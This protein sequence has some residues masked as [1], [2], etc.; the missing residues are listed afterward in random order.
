MDTP[1]RV[2]S[3]DL[4]LIDRSIRGNFIFNKEKNIE[5]V[6]NVLNY[7]D[8]NMFEISLSAKKKDSETLFRLETRIALEQ[9][10]EHGHQYPHLQINNFASDEDLM[11]KGNLHITLLVHSKE[12]L[13][14]SCNGFVYNVGQILTM[15]G[16]SF[17]IQT[18]LKEFFFNLEPYEELG[19]FSN[20]LHGL[21]YRT[22]KANKLIVEG[23]E[24]DLIEF[25]GKKNEPPLDLKDLFK[26][27]RILLQLKFLNP[28]LL[29]PLI[30]L[31]KEDPQ[32][33]DKC[34]DLDTD[35]C[36][37]K[38]LGKE[39]PQLKHYNREE[40]IRDFGK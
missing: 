13:E 26:V 27:L 1:K 11:K 14:Q 19:K 33:R 4:T 36:T 25:K 35:M 34:S 5:V 12:E 32:I 21:I 9:H 23:T 24:L 2:D 31:I 22:F 20:N 28:I 39:L 18:N 29:T 37:K 17:D 38:L 7:P 15:I 40:F 10:S 30:E 16:N 8:K 3:L 6:F